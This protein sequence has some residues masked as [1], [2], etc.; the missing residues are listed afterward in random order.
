MSP[1]FLRAFVAV[2]CA[3]IL[4]V[5]ARAEQPESKPDVK[6]FPELRPAFTA[7]PDL[8]PNLPRRDD[9][10]LV[11]A[12]PKLPADA[13]PLRKVLHEQARA[14]LTYIVRISDV[15]RTGNW[16]DGSLHDTVLLINAAYL[17]AA[18]LE[19][20]VTNRIPW[21]EERVRKLKGIERLLELRAMVSS[22]TT[23]PL[24]FNFTRFHRLQAEL[25]LL[26]LKNAVA[27]AGGEPR[28][29][30]FVPFKEFLFGRRG[31]GSVIANDREALS[32]S[33]DPRDWIYSA[34]PKLKPWY[35]KRVTVKDPDGTEG[36]YYERRDVTPLPRLPVIPADASP[37][38]KVRHERVLEGINEFQV[39][40]PVWP[41]TGLDGQLPPY[42]FPRY[43]R[44]AA[45]TYRAAAE[46]EPRLPDR[47]AWHQA[48]VRLF[49]VAMRMMWIKVENGTDP[50]QRLDTTL[51]DQYRAEADLLRLKAEVNKTAP[52]TGPNTA[53]EAS[54]IDD[55]WGHTP[56]PRPAFTAFPDLKPRTVEKIET[57]D[58]DGKIRTQKHDKDVVPLPPLPTVKAD[59]PLATKVR[60]EQVHEGLAHIDFMRE[61]V[62]NGSYS[63]QYFPEYVLMTSETFRAAAQLEDSP[64]KRIPWHEARIRAFK[65][66]ELFLE[67]RV[68][69][70]LSSPSQISDVRVRRLDAEAELLAL[71]AEAERPAIIASPL[72]PVCCCPPPCPP[73]RTGLLPRLFHRR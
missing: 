6:P 47:V 13:P 34:F 67:G 11:P 29:L 14:G 70:G 41:K 37:L 46:L 48:R 39:S 54:D 38:L 21:Y 49:K 22:G 61:V 26:A 71:K 59:T 56:K 73:R 27:K 69:D 42:W 58:V 60:L 12:L 8:K 64:A 62:L 2:L 17:V 15:I 32:I 30:R 72:P 3:C 63:S 36:G 52:A 5:G 20:T 35:E 25:D 24:G 45:D 31:I 57:K 7:F 68:R 51:F 55:T 1:A 66:I 28:P 19:D 43:F 4:V 50:P 44:N 16:S 53:R 10:L 65:D 9:P 40:A 23:P 33:D 18:E